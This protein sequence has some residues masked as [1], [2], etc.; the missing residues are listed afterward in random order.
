MEK[1]VIVICG[2]TASGKTAL[3]LCL[4][5]ELDTEII[6]ADSRQIYKYLSIG[7]AKPTPD[8]LKRVPHHLIDVLEPDIEYS[9]SKFEN[10]AEKIIDR[11]HNSNKI[12]IVVGGSGLYIHA[13]VEG[14]F[15]TTSDD[16]E[17]RDLL[18]DYR[19]QY[20][21]DYLYNMLLKADPVSA[22]K[23]LPQNYKRVIRALEVLHVTGKP[24]WEHHQH[25]EKKKKYDFIKISPDVERKLL[26]EI[27]E[28]RVDKMVTDGLVAEVKEVLSMGYSAS[29]NSLN[30]VGYKEII[31]FLNGDFSLERAI[32]LIKRNTR[33]FAKRQLT[34][35]RRYDN[36]QLKSIKS[37]GDIKKICAEIK[38]D[39]HNSL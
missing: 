20:G 19:A 11:I 12:P 4:A 2:P 33:R 25:Q 7:T 38:H 24:I 26:Y 9:A 3:S 5:Q 34:W 6:S 29:L 16:A 23:M 15:D 14:I 18:Q 28:T 36:L 13:L 39:I 22:A 1:R 30:T 31:S 10:D 37:A 27:I 17:Y 32:E 21:N 8:E 35:F